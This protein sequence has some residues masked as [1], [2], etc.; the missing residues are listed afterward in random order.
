MKRNLIVVSVFTLLLF[1]VACATNTAAPTTE[2]TVTSIDG[3]TITVQ[4]NAGGQPVTLNVSRS[5]R[6]QW[7]SGLEAGR[8]DLIVGHRVDVWTPAGSQTPTK[9]V[10][11]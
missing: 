4:P 1:A 8:A 5:T 11:R 6:V 10:I 7:A 2:G 9:I 3:S